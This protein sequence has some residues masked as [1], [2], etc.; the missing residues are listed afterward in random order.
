MPK[1]IVRLLLLI[2]AFGVAALAARAYFIDESFYKYGHYRGDAPAE[3]AADVPIYKGPE[4]CQSC[5]TQRFTEWS[6]SVHKVVVCETCHG[7]A[8]LHPA[9]AGIKPPPRPDKHL[10]AKIA[11]DE[12]FAKLEKLSI[13][14]DSVKL[15]TLCHEKMPGRPA[16][17]KQV[18]VS[19]HAQGQQCITCHNPHSPKIAVVP[20]VQK[21]AAVAKREKG[22]PAAGRKKAAA[23]AACHGE[24]GVSPNPRWPSLAGQQREYLAASLMAYKAG[25]RENAMMNGPAKGL[26]DADVEDL[27]AYFASASCKRAGAQS[28]AEKIAAGKQKAAACASCHGERGVSGNPAWPNLA[29]QQEG[30]LADALR[31]FRSNARPGTMMS[32]LVKTMSDADI[33]QV[34]AYY[35]GL[36]CK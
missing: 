2:A 25:R 32:G 21:T 36:S 12:R 11:Y 16:F 35:A 3:M 28:A 26:S 5:H 15:C 29:G 8:A 34:A 14:P 7:A 10:H 4:Y 18:E 20:V 17:Q 6:A 23:C 31:A 13:P 24:D 1:H 19:S 22:D 30:Y 27:A 9:A 33:D